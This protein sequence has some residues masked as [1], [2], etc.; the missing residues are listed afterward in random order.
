M[1]SALIDFT[2]SLCILVEIDQELSEIGP[3]AR[4]K[5][6]LKLRSAIEQAHDRIGAETEP[7]AAMDTG[8]EQAEIGSKP[9]GDKIML[10][11]R[12]AM[13]KASKSQGTATLSGHV[14]ATC[15]NKVVNEC[16]LLLIPSNVTTD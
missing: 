8:H 7:G 12:G 13:E 2:N 14:Q 6:I 15:E 9:R 11:L 5:T 10:K 3:K 16:V 1:D 4:K